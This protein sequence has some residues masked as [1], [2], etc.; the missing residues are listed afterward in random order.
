MQIGHPTALCLSQTSDRVY[1]GAL[2]LINIL[3]FNFAEKKF[4][5]E[6]KFS[7]QAHKEN[8]GNIF[9][10]RIDSYSRMRMIDFW[11]Q[12]QMKPSLKYGPWG[13]NY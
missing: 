13:G 11:L 5:L 8:I 4:N 9:V 1:F 6:K 2:N 12:H 10:V 7:D 3:T